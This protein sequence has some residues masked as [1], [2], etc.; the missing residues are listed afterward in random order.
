MTDRRS[1]K[2]TSRAQPGQKRSV[3]RLAAVQAI[4]EMDMAGATSDTVL[5]EFMQDRWRSREGDDIPASMAEPDG[6]FLVELVRGVT[7]RVADLDRAIGGALSEKWSVER[8]EVL[9]RA[10]MRAGAY[11][12]MVRTDV[13]VRVV[14]S[15]YLDVAHAFF[16]GDEPALVNGVLDRLARVLRP[17]ELDDAGGGDPARKP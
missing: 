16:A 12:L 7:D 1:A 4:Y 15:E 13:P 10:I 11:E 9:L 5:R 3:A 6:A 2:R 14:I 17:A 8:L